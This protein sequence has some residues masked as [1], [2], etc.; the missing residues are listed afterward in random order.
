[1][2]RRHILSTR[3]PQ[4][5]E[6]PIKPLFPWNIAFQLHTTGKSLTLTSFTEPSLNKRTFWKKLDT[7]K[8]QVI[9]TKA[10]RNLV[11]ADAVMYTQGQ[12]VR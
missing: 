10:L 7:R 11:I 5:A 2:Q 1:M 4:P 9:V 8:K 6:I 12:L 3:F